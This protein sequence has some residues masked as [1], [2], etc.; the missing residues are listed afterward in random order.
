MNRSHAGFGLALLAQVALLAAVPWNR[1]G[2]ETTGRTIWLKATASDRHDVMQGDY[3]RLDY[4]I[5]RLPAG[6]AEVRRGERVFVVLRQTSL[7]IWSGLQVEADMPSD[8][9]E[10]QVVIRGEAVDRGLEIH[11]FLHEEMD[12][13]WTADSVVTG[14]LH[15]AFDRQQQDKAV[16]GTWVRRN[17]IVYRDI[18]SYF[19]PAGERE[20]IREDLR[21]HPQEVAAQVR[22]DATGR[23]VLLQV[24]IQDRLYD[25]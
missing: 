1:A 20:R 17:T 10:D 7:G 24:R 3:L 16:A 25:F 21:A 11:A 23:A 5:P 2:D 18:E 8:L 14:R 13:S 15:V 19:V 6:T 12:G 9:P 22:V 4:E